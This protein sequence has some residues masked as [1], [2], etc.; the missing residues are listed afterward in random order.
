MNSRAAAFLLMAASLP[1][2]AQAQEFFQI[3]DENPLLRGIYLPMPSDM[4]RDAGAGLGVTLSAE[5]T[6]NVEQ[7]ASERLFVDGEAA[8]LRLAYDARLASN[9]RY[10]LSLPITRDSGGI[11]DATIDRWHG[12]FGLPRGSRPYFPRNQLRY[13]YSGNPPGPG[14]SLLLNQPHTDI[15]DLAA[16]VG[17]FAQDDDSHCISL[18]GG[19]E[20]PTGRSANLTGNGAWDASFWAHAAKRYTHWRLGAEA[21]VVQAFGDEVFGGAARRS[22]VFARGAA[23]WVAGSKWSWRAQ[24]EA[25]SARVKDTRLRFLGPSLILSLG[26]EVAL[27]N[28][29]RMQLGFSED[30]AV[31]TAPDVTFFLGVRRS[32]ALR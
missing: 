17:W 28:R 31:N 18:W 15:G 13:S 26:A 12:W 6:I 2:A 22:S 3:K 7:R 29:W 23:T 1:A 8:T 30:A 20:A 21:G 10:R 27:S 11:L 5:N 9:W 25:Q 14:D 24:L 32:G 16:E 19:L 4:R